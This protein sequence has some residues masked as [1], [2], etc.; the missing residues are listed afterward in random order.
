MDKQMTVKISG[1]GFAE[2]SIIDLMRVRLTRILALE[3][4]TPQVFV[5]QQV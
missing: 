4:Q 3:Q 2:A 1:S 5:V